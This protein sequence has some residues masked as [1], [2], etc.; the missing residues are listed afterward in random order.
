MNPE[1]KQKV[2]WHAISFVQTFLATFLVT[3]AGIIVTIP[4]ETLT[5]IHVWSGAAVAGAFVSA[6]RTALKI[7]W[8]QI[9]VP[10]IQHKFTFKL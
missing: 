7:A 1:I 10:I 2:I 9:V 8:E 3:V 4:T 5:D 6:G